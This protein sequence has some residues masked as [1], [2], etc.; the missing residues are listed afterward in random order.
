MTSDFET[1]PIGTMERLRRCEEALATLQKDIEK[2]RAKME[3]RSRLIIDANS[4]ETRDALY[5]Y[6]KNLEVA[7]DKTRAALADR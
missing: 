6:A 7:V 2:V 5:R 3:L 1:C 4:T